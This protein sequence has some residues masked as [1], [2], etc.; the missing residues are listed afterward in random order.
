MSIEVH[1]RVR[2]GVEHSV[3]ATAETVIHN[4][5]NTKSRYV[6]SK[7]HPTTCTNTSLFRG[8]EPLVYRAFEGSHVTVMAY[9]QTGS[10]KTHSM[11]GSAQD[12]GIVPRAV[13]LLL[14]QVTPE[15]D[16]VALSITEIY[17]DSVRDLLDASCRELQV[18]DGVG[19]TVTTDATVVPIHSM[20]DFT[21]I[22]SQAL[23]NRKTGVT[24]MNEHSSRSHM[25]MTLE[26]RRGNRTASTM[27]LVDLAGSESA[28]RANTKG[29]QLQEGGHI[30]QSLLSLGNVVNAIVEGRSHIPFRESKLTRLLRHSLGG[31]GL[32]C[33]VCCVNPSRD[34]QDQTNASL[35]FAQRAM[36]IKTDPVVEISVPPYFSHQF[37]RGAAALRQDVP[38]LCSET[39][40]RGLSDTFHGAF[41]TAG[42]IL[43]H[44]T[45]Q[46]ALV[47]HALDTCQRLLI[48]HDQAQGAESMDALEQ[49][50]VRLKDTVN[51]LNA[52][53]N[54]ETKRAREQEVELEAR[55]AKVSRLEKNFDVR[56]Q[57]LDCTLGQW[58]YELSE[59]KKTAVTEVGL[60]T[61]EELTSR[62]MIEH[63]ATSNFI[64]LTSLEIGFVN[65]LLENFAGVT[66]TLGTHQNESKVSAVDLAEVYA[67]CGI[68][69]GSSDEICHQLVCASNASMDR[70]VE[71][72]DGAYGMVQ[73][74]LFD[75]D[76]GSANELTRDELENMIQ[77]K[78]IEEMEL[79]ATR[80]VNSR[81]TSR[82]RVQDT[83]TASGGRRLLFVPPTETTSSSNTLSHRTPTRR[84]MDEPQPHA[85]ALQTPPQQ[86]TVQYNSGARPSMVNQNY[87]SPY[88]QR[89]IAAG[90]SPVATPKAKASP[91]AQRQK[92]ARSNP[93]AGD[94]EAA[95]IRMEVRSAIDMIRAEREKLL[96][97]SPAQADA[98]L[99]AVAASPLGTKS[100][101]TANTSSAQQAKPPLRPTPT[102]QQEEEAF[103]IAA[104]RRVENEAP[105]PAAE[106]GLYYL[107][108]SPQLDIA[109]HSSKPSSRQ[110]NGRSRT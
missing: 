59:A 110:A 7:V 100:N 22:S 13:R 68:P 33:I 73:G 105:R 44:H 85:H 95:G 65:N 66:A 63:E 60:L 91:S 39:Y 86:G 89:A 12:E 53:R 18:K 41:D 74:E 78:E 19:D 79:K 103:G 24:N 30:N 28:S 94:R 76:G 4:T 64:T 36:K 90:R 80:V 92:A 97:K 20:S 15:R 96:V 77:R 32:T 2:P 84:P 43:T 14:S 87:L 58:E 10:G 35:L 72:L 83:L 6:F 54:T 61:D 9:G 8:V 88:S 82:V 16:T 69:A 26:V 108:L 50:Y 27:S 93:H 102:E 62:V 34:N 52:S 107:S 101:S 11:L 23:G 71:D 56:A 99:S 25:I 70:D 45:S 29:V 67:Y 1:V 81:E 75:H 55:R 106:R 5:V 40:R 98:H 57:E 3:W 37:A 47:H 42:S 38:E 49:E 21:R 51:A 46:T 48:A 109:M 104:R 17:N 31:R